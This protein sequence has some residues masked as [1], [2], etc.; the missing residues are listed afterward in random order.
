VCRV[1]PTDYEGVQ[2]AADPCGGWV[3]A[4]ALYRGDHSYVR[5]LTLGDDGRR[6]GP[7]QRLGR[8]VFGD[9]GRHIQALAVDAR[10]RAVIAFHGA[11]DA[12]LVLHLKRQAVS[13]AH[14][15]PVRAV[16]IR[17]GGRVGEM[18]R[19]QRVTA[20]RPPRC[21]STTA[22]CSRCGRRQVGDRVKVTVRRF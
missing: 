13:F 17:P 20:A 5:A 10:G 7:V 2:V 6:V 9:D 1:A 11:D 22:A 12:M 3:I 8:G 14:H 15:A 16:S 18:Q 21:R 4:A 19:C